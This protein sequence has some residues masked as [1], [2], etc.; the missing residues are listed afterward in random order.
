MN[1]LHDP[2]TVAVLKTS[3]PPINV[4]VTSQTPVSPTANDAVT[5]GIKTDK[6]KSPQERIYLRWSSDFFITSKMVEAKGSGVNFSATIPGQTAGTAVQYRIVTSTADLSRFVA[7]G[8]ID[9]LTLAT[10]RTFKFIAGGPVL[11]QSRN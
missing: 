6:L 4:S 3:A 2:L 1:S 8:R 5:V 11:S 7:S 10:S 9:A